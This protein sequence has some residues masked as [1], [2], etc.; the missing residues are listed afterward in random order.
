[1]TAG[2]DI[3]HSFCLFLFLFFLFFVVF[4]CFCFFVVV[5]VVSFHLSLVHF[6][7]T[8]TKKTERIIKL[9]FMHIICQYM[10]NASVKC[11]GR[12]YS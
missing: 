10:N 1:M 2:P 5:V 3:A 8:K 4:F 7:Y 11:I 12:C 6:L 9:C